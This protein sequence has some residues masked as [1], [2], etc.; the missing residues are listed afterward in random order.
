MP[1]SNSCNIVQ[2]PSNTLT[3]FS[4]STWTP[5]IIGLTTAGVGTYTTQAGI[6]LRVGNIVY[7]SGTVIWTAHTGTGNMVIGGLPFTVRN[8]AN[9]Q[10]QCGLAYSNVTTPGGTVGSGAQFTLNTT[11]IE[12][13]G[14]RNNNTPN[15]FPI[16]T[17]GEFRVSGWYLI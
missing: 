11:R 12:P 4:E 15:P 13:F 6:Y 3:T 2:D 9:Y 8:L 5:I 1:T 14:L 10:P 17:T 7:V 16:D